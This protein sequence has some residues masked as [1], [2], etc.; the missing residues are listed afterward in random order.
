M[1]D[2]HLIEGPGNA[3]GHIDPNRMKN[4]YAILRDLNIITTDYDYK[5]SFTTEFVPQQ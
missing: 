5:Q 4:Q 1:L 2:F 3:A